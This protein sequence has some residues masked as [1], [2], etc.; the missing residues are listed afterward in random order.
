M[1]RIKV[2]INRKRWLRGTPDGSVLRN[3]NGSM[4]C[5]GHVA[6]ACS[7]KASTLVDRLTPSE[8]P[9]AECKKSFFYRLISRTLH[10]ADN[11][12]ACYDIMDLNDEEGIAQDKR[13]KA[14][15]KKLSKLGFD[16]S[17]F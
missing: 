16:V 8:V 17:F 11:S 2:R 14:L 4:C 13:E 3:E 5:L 10:D 1:K 7:I 12:I 15:T 9:D 6:R